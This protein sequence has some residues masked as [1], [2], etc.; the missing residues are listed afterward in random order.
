MKLID[1]YILSS[2]LH[3]LGYCLAAF[4]MVY[5]VYDLFDNL[6]DF[7][8]A[9]TPLREVVRFYA[10]LM[11]SVLI[12]I[13]PVSLMLAVLYSLSNLTRNNELT[14]MRASGV[15]IYR[16]M[17]PIA[18]T[19]VLASVLVSAVNETIAP[20]SA[21]WCHQFI[22]SQRHKGRM[23]V[24][25]A[26]NVAYKSQQT[27]RT[28][29]IGTFDTRTF[30]IR[31]VEV[32][33][34]R[35]DG[36]DESRIQASEGLWLDGRWWFRDLT[37]Q[38]YDHAGRPIGP[39]YRE[40]GREM[41]EYTETPIQFLNEV[42]DPQFLSAR[43]MAHYISTH[44]HLSPRTIARVRVDMHQRLA[45]PWT[46]LV[47]TLLGIPFGTQTG[48]RGALVGVAMCLLLF[49][50]LYLFINLGLILGKKEILPAWVAAWSP[51]LIFLAVGAVLIHRMR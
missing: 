43:D 37:I 41:R 24:Y 4:S 8:H 31:N 10:F 20:W 40:R 38:K 29:L 5:V 12:Y 44:T 7:I 14:A 35:P 26:H 32:V 42:R 46:C 36:S 27:G 1:R 33:Q 21:Y 17:I 47:V 19:G 3:P 16:L 9:H 23:D 28:W 2:F 50:L 45:M 15:S 34:Q 51:N 11:P 13:V 48:R 18:V 6:P 49:F 39:P 30:D 25:L 22:R